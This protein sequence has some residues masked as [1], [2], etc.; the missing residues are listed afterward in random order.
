MSPLW[1]LFSQWRFQTLVDAS[2]GE[3]GTVVCRCWGLCLP[4]QSA[5]KAPLSF[6][7]TDIRRALRAAQKAGKVVTSIT[8]NGVT[9]RFDE[10]GSATAN[11]WDQVIDDKAS[12]EIR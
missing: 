2:P 10:T 12:A 7:E 11:E 8:V 5:S 3:G 1:A 6:K 4:R 9:L